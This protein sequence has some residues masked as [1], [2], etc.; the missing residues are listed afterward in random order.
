MLTQSS[1]K[2][3]LLD[4]GKLL[5]SPK[6]LVLL[7]TGFSSGLPLLL[8]GSTLKF[9]MREDGLDLS[10]IGFFGLVGLPYTLKFVWAPLMDHLIP[11]VMGRRRGW[12]LTT[13]LALMLAIGSIAFTNPAADL[14]SLV[15][16]CL[17]VTFFSASQD[18]VLDAYRRES[19]QD[20]E[21]GIGSSIFIY[22]YRMGMLVAGAFALFLADQDSISWNAVYFIMGAFML[23]GIITTWFAPE[24]V[25]DSPPPSSF[26]EAIVGPFAEFFQ[27]PGALLI[28]AFILLYKIGDSMGSEMLSPLMVDLGISKTEYAVV[29]K[30]FG[31]IALIGGGL[32]G[33]LVVY[34]LGIIRSLWIF[35]FL[36]MAS[37]AGFVVLAIV[38]N[39]TPVLTAVIA[40]ETITSGL[41]QTA[42]VAFMASITNKRFTATQY[43]LLTSLM[44][45]PRV[46]A[47]SVTGVMAETIGWEAFYVFCTLVA[48]PGLLMIPK[49]SKLTKPTT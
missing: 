24:P 18:I 35:G 44:G 16:L 21:L 20:E 36:Q 41:G 3:W 32:L 47:G 13:Q 9:W 48:I 22:G 8:T 14:F 4:F 23:L 10:T 46:L 26:K 1:S 30:L 40:F 49:I 2:H 27:R 31:M 19:L 25:L 39:S 11:P 33:G 7:M 15:L 43:A 5:F 29:V 45:V 34:R 12:M 17:L 42:Y 37:T 28:L 38:G 6:M